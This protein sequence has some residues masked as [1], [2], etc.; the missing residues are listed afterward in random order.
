MK[1]TLLVIIV[2]ALFAAGAYARTRPHGSTQSLAFDDLGTGGGT[3][4]SGSFGAN[5]TF[6]F[7]VFVTYMGYNSLGLSFWLEASNGIAPNIQIS[8]VT[9]GTKFP[10]GT[11]NASNAMFNSPNGNSANFTSDTK[12]LGST[13]G[14]PT[15]DPPI[16]PG[17]YFVA[18]ITFQLTNAAAGNWILQSTVTSPHTSEVTSYDGTNF[19]D[20]NLPAAQYFLTIVPEPT[21]LALIGLTAVGGAVIAHRRRVLRG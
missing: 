3:A 7:D 18:H 20:N 6:S 11:Q 2:T 21:T 5:A 13:V 15:S 10:D 12:D 16:A 14:D 1:K 17:T 9:Y 4:N 19:A 8:S